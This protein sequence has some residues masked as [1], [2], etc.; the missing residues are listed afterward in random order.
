[1]AKATKWQKVPINDLPKGEWESTPK[2][3]WLASP[4]TM[5][6]FLVLFLANWESW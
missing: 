2:P 6:L 3:S 5:I 4:W 1:M